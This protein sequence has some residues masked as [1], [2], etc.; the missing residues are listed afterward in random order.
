ME[1]NRPVVVRVHPDFAKARM[2][3]LDNDVGFVGLENSA[4]AAQKIENQQIGD[5]GAIREAPSF[6]P[7]RTSVRDLPAEFGEEPRLADAGL[8]D[9]AH[10][11]AVSVFDLPKKIVQDREL[12][13]AIDED[14]RASRRRLAEPGASMGETPSP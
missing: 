7:R 6:D 13:L 1:Q 8:A 5:R 11:L 12:A 3:L 10:G 2:D 4:V 14:C 9:E